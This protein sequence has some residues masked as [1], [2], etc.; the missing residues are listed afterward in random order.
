MAALRC[1]T[2]GG[3]PAYHGYAGRYGNQRRRLMIVRVLYRCFRLLGAR[4]YYAGLYGRG[5]V[6]SGE[7]CRN[8]PARYA[9]A[10]RIPVNCF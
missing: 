2:P 6:L 4:I 7:Y 1:V 10:W 3:S 9:T 5:L 8:S